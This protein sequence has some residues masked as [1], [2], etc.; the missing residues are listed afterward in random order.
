MAG[1][2]LCERKPKI[3]AVGRLVFVSC[4]ESA[5]VRAIGVIL[6]NRRIEI[7]VGM[8]AIAADREP[9][10]P[11]RKAERAGTLAGHKAAGPN[12]GLTMKSIY[13]V[14]FTCDFHNAAQL[15]SVFGGET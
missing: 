15:P 7:A 8:E 14:F 2:P 9:V 3:I 10:F 11:G 1:L 6:Q 5:G 13:R 12:L 4:G